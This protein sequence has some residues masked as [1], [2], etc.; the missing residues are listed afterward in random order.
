M[1]FHLPKRLHGWRAFVGE[2]AIIVLGVLI[3]LFA[4]QLVQSLNDRSAAQEARENIRAEV[5]VNIGRMQSADTR[6]ICLDR[7]LDEIARFISDARRGRSL[8][9]VTWI[10]RPPVWDMENTRWQSAAGSGR[11]RL[12]Q[13]DEQAAIADIY[14]L[15]VDYQAEERVEQEAWAKLRGLAG[16]E[17]L[18][19]A[20]DSSLSDALQQARYSQWLL[21]IDS[22][23]AQ[24][25]ARRLGIR[26]IPVPSSLSPLCIPTDVARNDALKRMGGS[27]GEP[28]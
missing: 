26:G 24:D 11:S 18:S 22:K 17:S 28:L 27:Y 8:A 1:D 7:R 21:N 25:A 16:L 6:T 10:G 23:Q 5:A 9:A 4:Q 12:F 20:R 13:G 19:E 15:M 3:A 14:S 2:V